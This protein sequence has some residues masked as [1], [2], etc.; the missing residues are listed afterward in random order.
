MKVRVEGVGFGGRPALTRD[1]E[2]RLGN[3]DPFFELL[4]LRR[5]GRIEH[6]QFGPSV[7]LAERVGQNVGRERT[8][9]HAA[10]HDEIEA[11]LY[12]VAE[13]AQLG[14]GFE[15][16][17]LNRQ[18]AEGLFDDLGIARIV[19]PKRR[20]VR[21]EPVEKICGYERVQRG[22]VVRL[23]GSQRQPDALGAVGF[24][25]FL[26]VHDRAE[27]RRERVRKER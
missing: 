10:D 26:L 11:L 24:E 3:L 17:L 16:V 25:E 12:L 6:E 2:N 1:D 4:D 14:H 13:R 19:R 27:Q 9:A 5:T 15:H 21:P 18:P 20:I 23:G 8:A 7:V 22:F